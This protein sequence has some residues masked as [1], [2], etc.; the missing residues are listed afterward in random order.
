MK[1]K[2]L[3]P[4]IFFLVAFM[5]FPSA[6]VKAERS[7]YT[8][9]YDFW[10]VERESPDAYK[11]QETITGSKL[12][13]GDF[14]NPQ[15]LF[16]RD[17]RIYV[18][19]TGNH[20]I[21]ILEKDID[22]KIKFIDQFYEFTGDIENK[23]FQQPHDIFVT[24]NGELYIADTNNQRVI[25]LSP[26]LELIKVI[27]RPVDQTVDAASDFLPTKIVTDRAGR[28]FVLARNY[29][30]GFLQYDRDGRFI[31]Y[32]G[33]SEVKF[34]FTDYVWKMLSTQ[35]QKSQLT[36]FVPTE[37]NNVAMDQYGFLY[38]T[39]SI[40]EE[41]QLLT[42]E[43]KPIRKLNSMGT[44]ILVKNGPLPPIGDQ[45][46][47]DAGGVSGSSKF[48][49][50]TILDNDVYYALDRARGRIFGYDE[51]GNLLYAFGSLGNRLGY[52]QFPTALEHMGNDL[53]V[54]D[55]RNLGITFLT[56]TEYGNLINDA[57]KSYSLGQYDTSADYWREVLKLN[58]NY[59]MAYIGI[60]RSL[61]RQERYK[62]AMDYFEFALDDDNYSKAF[63]LYR[64]EWI[65]DNIV[66]IFISFFL[67]I[68]V[69][70]VIGKVRKIRREVAA[71]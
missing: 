22:S 53:L 30:K 38:A 20:R 33:A 58:G 4:I 68:T 65:E 57:I 23:T 5:L 2:K 34:S 10:E 12:G 69:P 29:N 56:L 15:G 59:D 62:E 25:H 35:K 47:G 28:S 41:Y 39:N 6:T 67:I 71:E 9:T 52:L 14:N 44:D 36:Q 46:W 3:M 19:D 21:V 66:W 31:G 45:W 17:N 51:Q 43:A 18:C 8:Y 32:M 54:L 63:Q 55:A 1:V 49:D 24:E 50:V 60:G 16:V 40:F 13:I 42:D 64:K 48:I 11:V 70:V 7:V 27:D 61:L 26:E 37:Y